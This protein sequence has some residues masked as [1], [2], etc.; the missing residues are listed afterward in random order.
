MDPKDGFI[1]LA[2]FQRRAGDASTQTVPTLAK[3]F[4]KKLFTKSTSTKADRSVMILVRPIFA[5]PNVR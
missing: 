4:L 5:S 2:T 3:G 1:S